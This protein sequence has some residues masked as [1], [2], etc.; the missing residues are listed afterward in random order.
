M[1]FKDAARTIIDHIMTFRDFVHVIM[2]FI[3]SL[4][5]ILLFLILKNNNIDRYKD[6]ENQ[7][8]TIWT[9]IPCFILLILAVP[10]LIVLYIRDNAN[11]LKD[12]LSVIGHQWYW[13]Y[14]INTKTIDRYITNDIIRLL[15]VDNRAL[16]KSSAMALIS[17]SDV[18]H[19]WSVPQMGVKVDA[20]P[21][22]I[23]YG[24]L[25]P[26]FEGVYFGQCREICG[27]NH[28]FIPI[29]LSYFS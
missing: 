23:R 25:Q 26:K 2:L 27:A 5:L 11:N 3:A 9:I 22:R 29:K 10:R 6:E 12:T 8:E 21:G 15:N 14:K 4:V 17:S 24:V 16:I 18:L 1:Y 28:A 20:V 13:T 19:S 7:L